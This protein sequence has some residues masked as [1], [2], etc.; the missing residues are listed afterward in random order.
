MIFLLTLSN[1]SPKSNENKAQ[2]MEYDFNYVFVNVLGR[3]SACKSVQP[4]KQVMQGLSY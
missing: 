2:L 1:Q 3:E 4:T